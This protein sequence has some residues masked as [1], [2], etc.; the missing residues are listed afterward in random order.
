MSSVNYVLTAH[1]ADYRVC[2]RHSPEC[3][4]S[5][6]T[7][8]HPDISPG[9]EEIVMPL[10][11]PF[12]EYADS[13]FRKI[14][15]CWRRYFAIVSVSDENRRLLTQLRLAETFQNR[16]TELELANA[17]LRDL[18]VLRRTIDD[19]ALAAEVIARDPSPWYRS[20]TVN[21]GKSDGVRK[22]MPVIVPEGAA[23]LISHVSDRHSRVLLITDPS[24]AVDAIV[25]RTRTRGIVRGESPG[26]CTCEYVLRRHEI[27]PGD[28]LVSSGL[29]GIF[30]K[31]LRLG[32]VTEVMP[33]SSGIFQEIRLAPF[34]DFEKLEEV[35]I[36]LRPP[37]ET[38]ISLSECN[39]LHR[40][41]SFNP[42]TQHC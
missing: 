14:R 3:R 16:N 31:G 23:G 40:S 27:S 35:L 37:A 26:L 32:K 30:P 5:F 1:G 34:A 39:V 17:R 28:I 33:V 24:S 10:A 25:Q 6:Y 15:E 42:H 29:D 36:I 20:M 13:C 21:K 18:L 9:T 22:G 41:L 38:E 19:P 11:S 4:V 7:I 8:R 12:Q 2:H